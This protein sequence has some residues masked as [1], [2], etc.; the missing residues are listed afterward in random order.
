MKVENYDNYD[1]YDA[2]ALPVPYRYA[3][4]RGKIEMGS[5]N[6]SQVSYPS[7]VRGLYAPVTPIGEA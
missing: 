1:A 3:R 5:L 4:A 6:V 7:S 2:C